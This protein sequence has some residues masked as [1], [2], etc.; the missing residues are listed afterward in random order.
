MN[1]GSTKFGK[2]ATV[3]F[4]FETVQYGSS[5]YPSFRQAAKYFAPMIPAV[6]INEKLP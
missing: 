6:T 5:R 4:D 1:Q 3:T 2:M